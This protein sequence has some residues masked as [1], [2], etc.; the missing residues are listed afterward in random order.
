M[1]KF[2]SRFKIQKKNIILR[3]DLNV[4]II[5]NRISDTSRIIAIKKTINNLLKNNNKVFLVSH[6]GRPSGKKN[7]KYSLKLIRNKIKEILKVN[8]LHFFDDNFGQKLKKKISI[9]KFGEV[10]LLENIRFYKQ[11]EKNDL[12]FAKNLSNN[13][14]LYIN[15]AFSA[16]HRYHSSVVGLTKFLPSYAGLLFENELL[17]LEKLFDNSRKPNMAIIGGSKVSTKISIIEKLICSFDYLVIGGGMANTFLAANNYYLGKSFTEN[18]FI[19]KVKKIQKLAITKKCKILLPKDLVIAKK[20][21]NNQ[22]DFEICSINNIKVDYAAYDIGPESIDNIKKLFSKV[23]TIVWNGPL[24]AFEYRPFD[25]S[26]KEI[27]NSLAV[28]KKRHK[29]TVVI[30][31]GDTIASI[32]KVNLLK[33]YSYVSTSGGAFLEWLKGN[34][35]PGIKALK[36]N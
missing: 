12:K 29:L 21:K 18:T 16:S 23:K 36:N 2:Q 7:K 17:N 27:S 22:K 31:G 10:C 1:I 24:G 35:L 13:F 19:K 25:K 33:K 11:E 32:K 8:K 15:D 30:G 3:V 26:T 4:P 6:L 34:S 28:A 20:L 14:D 5:N 9:M